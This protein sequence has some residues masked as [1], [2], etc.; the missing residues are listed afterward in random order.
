MTEERKRRTGLALAILAAVLV[1]GVSGAILFSRRETTRSG[2]AKVTQQWYCPMHPQV[3]SD[4][5]GQC[6]I[7]G[8]N[9]APKPPGVPVAAGTSSGASTTIPVGEIG[10]RKV[11]YWYDPMAPGSRFDKPG[12][13]P[14]MDMDLVPKFAD[15]ESNAAGTAAHPAPPVALS[16]AAIRASGVATTAV[17]RQ[18]LS[19]SIRA[20]GQIAA[21]ETRL[22]RVAARLSGRVERLYVN[23]TGQPVRRGA[24]LF[25][26][27]SPDLVST[28][29][30]YLLTLENRRRLRNA[31]EDAVRSADSLVEAARDRLRLWGISNE[32]IRSLEASGRPEL[33]MTF[34]SPVS[35][36]VLQKTAVEGQ[37]VQEGTE[38]Y[39]LA[40]LSSVWL[41]AQVYESDIGR[42]RVGQPVVSTLTAYPG[43]EFRGKVVFIEP[44]LDPEART[45]R[46]R[47]VLPNALGELKPGM[48]ADARLEV[49]LGD[50][51]SITKSAAIDTG[52]RQVVYVETSAGNFSPR[53]V[54]LGATAG[55]RREVIAG[56]RE[57]EKVVAAANF[58]VDSQAQLAAG[59]SVQWSGALE[60]KTTP[61]PQG[62]RP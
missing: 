16:A 61:T 58:F 44:V 53:D 45:T 12:K 20:V 52:A 56:L 26:L 3:V 48:F 13:S 39:L 30:E 4:K 36:V 33:A 25:S 42:I 6:P 40:D 23:F 29:R 55:D 49:P 41:I 57:G 46:V 38:L 62:G 15:E 54:R 32:Q 27:Y 21:D 37:Y 5:P 11:L 9:L 18:P 24:P 31:S 34:R 7:C 28:Q 47:A 8:M 19:R 51:L 10:G 22:E 43:R 17:V 59:S 2:A 60:V 50:V 35:G 14:F 1:G